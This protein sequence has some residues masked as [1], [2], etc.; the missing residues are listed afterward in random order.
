MSRLA[1]I[2][3]VGQLETR[4]QVEGVVPASSRLNL[5]EARRRP[6][7]SQIPLRYLVADRFEAGRGPVAD[8]LARASSFLAS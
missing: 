5:L 7:R 8:L 6:I 2:M 3:G 1:A 4:F